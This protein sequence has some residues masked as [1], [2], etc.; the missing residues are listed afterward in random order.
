MRAPRPAARPT[1]C[2]VFAALLAS[3][4]AHAF[5]FGSG[6]CEAVASS[7]YMSGRTGHPGEDGGFRLVSG[8]TD[9]YGGEVQSLRLAHEAGEVFSG[10]LVYAET[11]AQQ[12]DGWF[13]PVQGTTLKLD[14]GDPGPTLTHADASLWN[15]LVLRWIAPPAAIQDLTFRALLLRADPVARRGTDFYETWLM[16][17]A[18]PDGVF[19]SD[20]DGTP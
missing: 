1:A 13:D 9:Y 19:R 7:S 15:T 16:L 10:F 18:A 12:R 6:S 8:R 3:G 2:L 20:F 4:A 11:P 14:C 17:R 5:P